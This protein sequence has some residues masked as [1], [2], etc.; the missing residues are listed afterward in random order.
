LLPEGIAERLTPAQLDAILAHEL[1]HVRRRDNLTAAIHMVVE[2][3]FW[4][5]PMV[6]WIRARLIDER[7]RA[8]DQEVLRLGN[9]PEAY[10]E[11]ILESCKFYLESPLACVSG[12]TGS[13]LKRRIETIM[14]NP[15]SLPVSRPKRLLLAV[16]SIGAVA[17]PI[18]FGLANAPP[19]ID[20]SKAEIGSTV[21]FE[22]A[23][24]RP[25]GP[26][27]GGLKGERGG[28]G[29]GLEHR[30]L[31]VTNMNLLGLLI[32]AYGI[33]GCRPFG[34][35]D[36]VLISGGPDWLKKDGFDIAA[37]MPDDSPDYTPIQQVNFHA[38]QLQLML[39]ALLADRFHLQVHRES[40]QLSVL[41]LTLGKK[42]P[43]F[44]K[45]DGAEAPRLMFRNPQVRPD[46]Q[47]II[48]LV[49]KSGSMQELV[50]LYAKFMDRPTVDQTGLRDRYDFT[51]EYE[52]NADAPGP[53]TELVGP[54][55]FRAFEEQA[56]LKWEAT[57]AP[58][59]ILVIDHA[60]KP[61][62]N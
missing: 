35:G 37:K 34:G 11:G 52:S 62:A 2:T 19:G 9:D 57:K 16:A 56:G 58:V 43:K 7:E 26:S 24:V 21:A 61:S 51:V 36:C 23:S 44:K 3:V 42:G 40:K 10:A 55:L 47:K 25:S 4:F 1:C 38:P 20:Q 15:I 41:A 39:Q 30:R 6:W 45:V 12:V 53:F 32:Q 49:V 5:H 48:Q 27:D 17:G 8:C 59:E 50:D 22:V 33:R 13:N 60:E 29:F 18:A 31:T 28:G 14:A 54:G 46:G